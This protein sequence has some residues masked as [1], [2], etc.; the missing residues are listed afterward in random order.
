MGGAV[1]LLCACLTSSQT[2]GQ[3]LVW[4]DTVLLAGLT[5]LA[6]SGSRLIKFR[7]T[8]D[9]EYS[10]T[11]ANMLFLHWQHEPNTNQVSLFQHLKYQSQINNDCN[12]KIV[13]S[14]VHDLGIQ[15]FFDSISRFQPDEN[16]LDTR[17]EVRLTK[18]FTFSVFSTL[19]TRLF[20]AYNYATDHTG[21]LCKTLNASFLTPMIWT[22]SAG[23]GWTAPRFATFSFG[24]SSAKLTYIHNKAIFD[25]LKVPAFYGVP[26]NKNHLFEYGLSMHLLLDRNFKNRV[27]WNCDVL[28]FKNYKKPIDLVM[29]N[30]VGIRINKFLKTSIQT[31]LYYESA[32]SRNLQLENVISMGFCFIL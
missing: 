30:L 5:Q 9:L 2:T 6:D 10:I 16:T 24:L 1:V 18:N 32:V 8:Q 3:N 13:N 12:F 19:T 4:K 14:F 11:G 29:N 23:L 27:H 17:L 25:Q 26:K 15:C 20:N 7:I 21:N 31:N 22:F 28:L